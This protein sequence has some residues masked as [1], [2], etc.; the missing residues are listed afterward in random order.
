MHLVNAAGRAIF[1]GDVIHHA[2]QVYVPQWNSKF[3][4][5]PEVARTTRARLLEQC[6]EERALLFPGHF[7][8]PHVARIVPAPSG[9]DIEFVEAHRH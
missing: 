1:A 3:C 7:G 4:E 5:L 6:T 8:A 9:F 2:L